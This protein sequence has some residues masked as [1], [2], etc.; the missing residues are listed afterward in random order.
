MNKE[1]YAFDFSIILPASLSIHR[2]GEASMIK[3]RN[4][5]VMIAYTNHSSH[6]HNRFTPIE[7]DNDTAC[8]CATRLSPEGKV[9]D[10]E[11]LLVATP[12]N[13]INV[14]SP[15]LRWLPDGKMGL[16]FSYR[17]SKKEASRL[18][19]TSDDEGKTW[20]EP[21]AVAEGGYIT[22]CHDRFTILS[23]GRLLAPLHYTRDWDQHYLKVITAQSDDSGVTWQYSNSVELPYVGPM[24]GW[25]GGFIESGCVEPSVVERMDGSL[26]MCL[27]TAMG[28]L[29]CTESFDRGTTW[30]RPHSMEVIS[31][32]AP[33]HLSRI[34]GTDHLLLIWTP[35]YDLNDNLSGS[36]HSIMCCI[37]TDGG[38]SWPYHRRKILVEDTN[39]SVDYPAVLYLNKEVWLTLRKSNTTEISG[40]LTSSGLMK[41][42]IDWLYS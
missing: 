25:Q 35:N 26:L 17:K 6:K 19:L 28:T 41:I 4:D 32:Q 1:Y 3:L 38:K 22:G 18:M 15:A 20:S 37:S 42:P 27:R 12:P 31:P 24:Y 8:I 30:E 11:W 10:D 36:R 40:G 7:G 5:E 21:V 29:F 9:L 14:M 39:H 23:D 13:V 2:R 16:L 34:P 33:A